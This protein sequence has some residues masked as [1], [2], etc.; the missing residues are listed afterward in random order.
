MEI[1]KGKTFDAPKV[2]I[3]G[4]AGVGKST[5]AS[6][7]KRPIFM[8]FEG[9][10]NYIGVDRTEVITD[11]ERFYMYLND[12]FTKKERDYDTVVID[13]I[14]WFV[15][16]AVEKAAGINNT[17]D[18]LQQTLNRSNGGYGNGKQVLENFIR[19]RLLTAL[20]K[21]TAKGVCV[22][23]IAHADKKELMDAEGVDIEQ[24][25]P[26]IDVNT[27]HAFIEWCDN[28]F[29]LKKDADG[30]RVLVLESDDVALAKNRLGLKG[31]R[32]LSDVNINDLL[33]GKEK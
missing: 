1:I 21:L 16:R 20:S 28:I 9:G 14:D 7:L 18:G 32:K 25:T 26:K 13:S 23:L 2:M 24:I 4:L 12:L 8:D 29:Y 27:L 33:A 11:I 17:P 3:Y 22:C 30:E 19:T 15:R 6:K 31:E 5:L 10:A